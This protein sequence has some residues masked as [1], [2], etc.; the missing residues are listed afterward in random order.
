MAKEAAATLLA[1][2]QLDKENYSDIM[3]YEIY[4]INLLERVINEKPMTEENYSTLI[5][6]LNSDIH[7]N[8]VYHN[9]ALYLL[10]CLDLK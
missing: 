2:M 10:I 3:Q 1:K 6:R 8:T 9:E 5:K 4:Y 7:Y